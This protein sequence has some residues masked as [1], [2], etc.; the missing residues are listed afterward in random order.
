MKKVML[1]LAVFILLVGTSAAWATPVATP[2]ISISDLT[3]A[4]P[5]VAYNNF[6][7]IN[8][9]GQSIP[10]P[11]VITLN[12]FAN[13]TG[14]LTANFLTAGTY[15]AV[16]L[17]NLNDPDYASS[18]YKGISDFATLIVSR[19]IAGAQAINLTFF[20]DGATGFSAAVDLYLHEVSEGDITEVFNK[21]ETGQPQLL[22][23]FAGLKVCAASDVAPVPVPPSLLLLGS[24]LLGVG[25]LRF[26]KATS[27]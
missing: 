11:V 14:L 24:G 17:E 25:V 4:A 7:A 16:M 22:F 21:Y 23:D 1:L 18:S 15:G 13:V 20:S 26:R 2:T 9:F 19:A 6:P 10:N 27:C 5:T 3:E 8:I 12:E